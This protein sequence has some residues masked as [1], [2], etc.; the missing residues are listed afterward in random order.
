MQQYLWNEYKKKIFI[1][2]GTGYIGRQLIPKLLNLSHS[3]KCLVREESLK[4][5]PDKSTLVLGNAL[6][7]QTYKGKIP[8]SD[9]FIHLV[10]VSHPS[11]S[12]KELFRKV[13]L[14]SLEQA[15]DAALFSG[16]KNFIYISV[17]HPAPIMKD[18]T[19][20]REICEE[21]IISSGIGATILRPWYVLGPGHR[22]PY[23]LLPFYKVLE[24]IPVTSESAIR[25]ATVTLNQ[26][27]NAIIYAVAN[28]LENKIRIVEVPEIK[29]LY[30]RK[31]VLNEK[32]TNLF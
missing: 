23:L 17:A 27:V 31:S 13:D 28:P 7:S 18:Y 19:K 14:V 4:K 10:G 6:D 9:T 20:V 3:V 2:G 24:K 22:W 32:H 8:E 16:I 1:T 11:P 21:M 25:L 12:K 30:S 5:L 15:L 29:K 26:M